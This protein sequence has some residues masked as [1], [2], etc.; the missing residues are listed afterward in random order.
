[1]LRISK[2]VPELGVNFPDSGGGATGASLLLPPEGDPARFHRGVHND[3]PQEALGS[4]FVASNRGKRSITIDAHSEA[5]AEVLR[6][7]VAQADVFVSNYRE[8]ALERMGLG[9]ERLRALN[10]RLVYAVVNGFGPL[11]PE[12]DKKMVD[13]AAQARGGLASVTGSCRGR[14]SRTRRERCSSRWAS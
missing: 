3:L 9:Y 11:G 7:L 13:G 14:S 4:Q 5:G 8:V 10:P 12:A 6:T 2:H 1:M